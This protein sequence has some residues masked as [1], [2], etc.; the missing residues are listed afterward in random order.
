MKK[1]LTLLVAV[2]FL[3]FPCFSRAAS[4]AVFTIT[5]AKTNYAVGENIQISLN[6][7]AGSYVTTLSVIDFDL[8]TS[9]LTVV[10]LQDQEEPFVPGEIFSTA[11]I[12]SVEDDLINAVVY[13]SPTNPPSSRSGVVGTINFRALKE[14][15]VTFS[16]DRIEAAE[17]SKE[18]DYVTTSASSLTITVGSSVSSKTS[19]STSSTG[20]T[21]SSYSS[22]N[23]TP[24]PS[25]L[26][27]TADSATTGPELAAGIALASGFALHLI[28]KRYK[29][30]TRKT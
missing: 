2:A 23:K 1:T 29:I 16:Y 3:A 28:R 27:T 10:E 8:K 6:V 18:D 15:T 13:V 14:G 19:A 5:S 11:G 25:S 26:A 4:E 17:E 9:D 12:Q 21:T 24:T 22:Y 30:F 7:D 20:S